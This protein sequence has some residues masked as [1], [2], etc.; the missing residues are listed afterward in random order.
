MERVCF[1]MRLAPGQEAK[2]DRMHEAVWPELIEQLRVNGVRNYTLF[3]SGTTV[4]AYAECEP[5]GATA[6]GKVART[7]IDQRWAAT[8]EGV[9]A[10]LTDKNGRLMY[11]DQVWHMD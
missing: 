7:S 1:R 11:V 5:D 6:F 3:R 10:E 4:V 2:Y 8:F 9:I